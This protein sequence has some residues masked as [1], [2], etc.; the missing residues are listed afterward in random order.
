LEYENK[1]KNKNG[2]SMYFAGV[3]LLGFLEANEYYPIF[4]SALI[5]TPFL[6]LMFAVIFST[7]PKSNTLEGLKGIGN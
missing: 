3:A 1:N 4:E 2:L 5:A 6:G 7:K